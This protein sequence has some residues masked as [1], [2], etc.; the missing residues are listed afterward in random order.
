[1][2]RMKTFLKYILWLV[3][4]FIL[5]NFLISVG[6]NSTYK[7]MNMKRSQEQIIIY[8]SEATRVN[9]R[10]RGYIENDNPKDLYGKY[11]KIEFYSKRDIYLGKRYVDINNFNEEKRQAFEVFFK[12]QDVNAYEISIVEEKEEPKE[13]EIIPKDLTRPEI[14]ITT[15]MIFLIFW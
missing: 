5:S 8:Q 15:A 6:L 1:M 12:L 14:L 3:G 10:I 13:I 9:G 4:F 2:D 11:L 7:V